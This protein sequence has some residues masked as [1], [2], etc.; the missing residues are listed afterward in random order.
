MSEKTLEELQ[1]LQQRL[2]ADVNRS[3]MMDPGGLSRHSPLV[4][5]LDQVKRDIAEL[6]S[7]QKK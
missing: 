5:N 3:T 2:Q 7:E 6:Q 4:R 1:A